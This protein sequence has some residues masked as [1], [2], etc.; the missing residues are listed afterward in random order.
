MHRH[1]CNTHNFLFDSENQ[2][3]L[4]LHYI[5]Y[6]EINVGK[7][8]KLRENCCFIILSTHILK[9]EIS[10][11][12]NGQKFSIQMQLSSKGRI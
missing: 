10:G 6:K 12:D 1:E 9:L 2:T 8:L 4:F 7:V 5:P 3:R 11:C